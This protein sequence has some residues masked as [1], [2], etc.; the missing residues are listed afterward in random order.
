MSCSASAR[1]YRGEWYGSRPCRFVAL[2]GRTAFACSSISMFGEDAKA[3]KLRLTM[4]MSASGDRSM[5]K[6]DRV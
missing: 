6:T 1:V 4:A 2:Y 5:P 3:A